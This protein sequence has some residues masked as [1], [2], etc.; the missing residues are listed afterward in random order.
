[1][2][3]ICIKGTHINA[4]RVTVFY[5]KDGQLQVWF[6]GFGAPTRWEDLDRELYVK[7]CH[8][9]GVR[10]DEEDDAGGKN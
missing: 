6:A 4:H 3:W 2:R 5:W 1:M 9:L 10:P 8:V 7:M